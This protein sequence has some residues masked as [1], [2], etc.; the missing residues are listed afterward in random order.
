M[1]GDVSCPTA[2]GPL[3]DLRVTAAQ[4]PPDQP[5]HAF[6]CG[7]ST[8]PCGRGPHPVGLFLIESWT[9]SVH[10]VPSAWAAC[11]PLVSAPHGVPCAAVL[12]AGVWIE[13]S[14]CFP[15]PPGIWFCSQN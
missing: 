8:Q 10:A 2:A 5:E 3:C 14:A 11:C 4:P 7:V 13:G 12:S 1:A 15:V 6:G 9:L